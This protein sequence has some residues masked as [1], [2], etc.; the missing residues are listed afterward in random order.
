MI[1]ETVLSRGTTRSFSPAVRGSNRAGDSPD[2]QCLCRARGAE[3]RL[4]YER[5]YPPAINS[6]AET[7]LAAATASLV[8]ECQGDMLPSMAAEDF[9]G[10]L[11]K[12]PGA[13]IWIASSVRSRLRLSATTSSVRDVGE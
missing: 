2:R 12:K 7:E 1:P 6:A 8:G 4:R 9:A 10:C 3:M 5:R 13:Y 11:E